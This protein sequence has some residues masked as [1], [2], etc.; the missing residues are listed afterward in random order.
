MVSCNGRGD[1]H[2]K[3]K[4]KTW[5]LVPRPHDRNIIGL[6]W[7]FRTKFNPNGSLNKHKAKLVVKGYSQ[8][9]TV[10]YADTF[11]LVERHGT[12]RLI[13]AIIAQNGWQVFHMDV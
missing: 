1:V 12:T 8:I 4:N 13:L 2:D 9:F 5:M 6:K 7:V 3:K 10:D 11:A